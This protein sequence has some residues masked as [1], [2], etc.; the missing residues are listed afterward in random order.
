M[1]FLQSITSE[2]ALRIIGSRSFLS[3]KELVGIEESVG[4]IAA[5]NLTSGEPIPAFPKSLVDGY[6]VKSKDV[7][8]ARET[9]PAFLRLGGQIPIG[10]EAR[11]PVS[12]GSCV[13]VSTGSMMPPDSD[14]VVMQEFTR[15]MPDAVEI[16]KA[17]YQGENV[18]YAGE[19]IEKGTVVFNKGRRIH[20]IDT[21]VLAALGISHIP[22]Y[23]MPQVALISTGDEI[24]AIDETPP[25]GKS[26]DINRYIISALVKQAGS[27][28][29]F[30]G[31]AKDT[32]AEI[33]EKL[34]L[35]QGHDVIILS[36]GSSK[37]EHDFVT[38]SVRAL[39]GEILFHGISVKPGKPTIFGTLFGK[40]LFGLPG[41]PGSCAMITV[42][43]VVPLLRLLRG[44]TDYR[45]RTVTGNLTGNVPSSYGIE[46]YVR[47][48]LK[49]TDKGYEVEP[50]FA[51]SAVISSLARSD[52]YI[53][54]P[55]NTE[56]LE[57]GTSVE[58]HFFQ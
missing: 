30:Q 37:G 50:V 4:R 12:D 32:V 53:I 7:Q 8:G 47:V 26:R 35:S 22:V 48:E 45:E 52:G 16:T 27:R 13:Y 46:E 38:E 49:R 29:T 42:R 34:G 9:S 20:P 14:S 55:T 36:G 40:P 57:R 21:G 17:V 23:K 5:D 31:H 10:E 3:L 19:D 11:T 39:G 28:V 1:E 18:C 43:F 58:V 51:K 6:A 15:S 25:I 24:I 54:V 41:H 56:G 2:E 44:E 33:T